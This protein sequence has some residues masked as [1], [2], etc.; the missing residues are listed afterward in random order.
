M[1]WITISSHPVSRTAYQE[2]ADG[3]LARIKVDRTEVVRPRRD[4]DRV[5][6][7]YNRLVQKAI[8]EFENEV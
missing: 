4:T 8:Q 5:Y 7:A 2:T 1:Q 3:R 6:A